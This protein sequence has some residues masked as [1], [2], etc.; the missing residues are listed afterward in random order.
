VGC[1]VSAWPGVARALTSRKPCPIRPAAQDNWRFIRVYSTYL[2]ASISKGSQIGSGTTFYIDGYWITGRGL[3]R[4]TIDNL[5][6]VSS[7]EA[8]PSIRLHDLWL[9]KEFLDSQ[10]SLR[11]GQIALDDEFYISQ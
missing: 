7:I 3:S 6:A 8:L 10:V 2:S 4:N 9:Q 1:A 5:L 11:V